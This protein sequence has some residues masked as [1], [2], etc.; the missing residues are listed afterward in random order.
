LIVR[1]SADSGALIA[2]VRSEVLAL[3]RNV[4]LTQIKTMSD[5]AAEGTSRTRFIALLL[6]FFAGVALLLSAIGIYGVMAYNVSARTREMGIRIA[7]GAQTSDVLR[8][9]MR[10][11]LM[12]IAAGLAIG[13]T[14]AWA[15]SRVLASQLYEVSASD[16]QTFVIVALVLA[17][18]ASVACYLPARRA[19]RTDPISAL[20]N[21]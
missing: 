10:D 8:L 6:G 7:L 17:V 19:T 20:R 15:A 9:V 3:D 14:A 5:R 12:L 13:L 1:S 11:G 18:V 4:P 2:A 16:P 21:E